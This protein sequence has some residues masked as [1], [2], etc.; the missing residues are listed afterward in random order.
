MMP[1]MK[2]LHLLAVAS[3]LTVP[4]TH[5]AEEGA[6]PLPEK[7]ATPKVEAQDFEGGLPIANSRAEALVRAKKENRLVVTIFASSAC[8]HCTAFRQ[9]VLAN[10]TFK[11]FA[12]EKLVLV[13]FDLTRFD[14]MTQFEQDMISILIERY[15]VKGT[16]HLVIE[17]PT[18]KKLL[19]TEG[20]RGTPGDKVVA[21]MQK[22]WSSAFPG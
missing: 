22:L 16:P 19:E 8:P 7:G 18:E 9:G 12:K 10:E 20:Y 11:A 13:I 17:A 14:A 21:D 6:S 2:I 1:A 3:F 4:I 5:A 15:Q